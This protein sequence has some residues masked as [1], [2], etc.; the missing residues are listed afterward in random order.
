MGASTSP[1][2]I[3]VSTAGQRSA[4]AFAQDPELRAKLAEKLS[5]LKM[6]RSAKTEEAQ[7]RRDS[8]REKKLRQ[9]EEGDGV[10]ERKRAAEAK[11]R[12][13]EASAAQ[14]L[15]DEKE[16]L[17]ATS[18]QRNLKRNMQLERD[19]LER[20]AQDAASAV[21]LME[22]N[23]SGMS[24]DGAERKRKMPTRIVKARD[25]P[26]LI[27][28]AE[29]RQE[30]VQKLAADSEHGK[31]LLHQQR[32]S[33][34]LKK[35][36]GTRM[37]DDPKLLRRSLKRAER[38]K[39]KSAEKW[40]ARIKSEKKQKEERLKKREENIKGRISKKSKKKR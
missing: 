25:L 10:T 20:E 21:N 16:R 15:K 3:A 1:T 28:R 13:A 19:R 33:A 40:G 31:P 22:F 23:I 34:A 5:A 30:R 7:Q 24:G 37:R 8:R 2:A 38:E 9:R 6:A 12:L 35:A 32:V 11:Q 29:K 39:K 17:A 14:K 27:E 36:A 18:L 4:S 26:R